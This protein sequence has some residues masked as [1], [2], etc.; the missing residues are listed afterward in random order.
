MADYLVT[1]PHSHCFRRAIPSDLQPL[2]GIK[3]LR[4]SLRT[5]RKHEAK[6]KARSLAAATNILFDTIRESPNMQSLPKE[7]LQRIVRNYIQEILKEDEEHRLNKGVYKTSSLE[8]IAEGNHEWHF[9]LQN[10]IDDLRVEMATGRYDSAKRAAEYA[11]KLSDVSLHGNSYDFKKLCYELAHAKM[12]L[13]RIEMA[14]DNFK[15]SEARQMEEE[16][17][18]EY[19]PKQ[20]PI[21]TQQQSF[22]TPSLTIGEAVAKHIEIK[23]ERGDWSTG[24]IPDNTMRVN[25]FAKCVGGSKLM[26]ELTRDD[27][28]Y[29]MR[30]LEKAPRANKQSQKQY[31]NKRIAQLLKQEIPPCDR[32][33]Q[34]SIKNFCTCAVG[35]LN[36]CEKEGY[37]E[38]ASHL[39]AQL[40]LSK[41]AKASAPQAIAREYFSTKELRSLFHGS[42]YKDLDFKHSYQFWTPL[43]AL[44]TGM[45]LGEICQL[46][47]TDIREDNGIHYIDINEIGEKHVKSEAGKRQTP[48][49]PFLV[50]LGLLDFVELQRK[51]NETRLFSNLKRHKSTGKWGN[52]VTKWFTKYRRSC[53]VGGMEG[54]QSSLVFH[55]FRHTVFTWAKHNDINRAIVQETLGHE[56]SGKGKD[57]TAGYE[58]R[59]PLQ[60]CYNDFIKKLDFADTVDLHYLLNNKKDILSKL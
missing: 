59:F 48:I 31:K 51:R 22:T 56:D 4:Y 57:V 47:L 35:F 24:S 14:K 5:M 46:E 16:L 18:S 2:V 19:S 17:L 40:H 43:I 25:Y 38:K 52:N 20:A 7:E 23:T 15:V 21:A 11:L 55:S 58:G 9:E 42:V 60:R 44:F 53:G 39:T 13:Y 28:R 54:E 49:H 27:I 8:T 45:R 50:D 37:L 10:F 34:K 3:E 30:V 6:K 36:W 1:T 33:S 12:Q 26:N 41:K 32:Y 29:Y